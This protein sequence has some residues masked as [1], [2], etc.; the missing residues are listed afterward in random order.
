[1]AAALVELRSQKPRALL[2]LVTRDSKRF[3]K[4]AKSDGAAALVVSKPVWG[5]TILEAIREQ[6]SFRRLEGRNS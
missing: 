6:L 2:V 4:L 3:E 5:W 1:V